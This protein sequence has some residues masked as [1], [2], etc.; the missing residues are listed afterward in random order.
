MGPF[1]VC[2]TTPGPPVS[3]TRRGHRPSSLA[4]GHRPVYNREKKG[5]AK[6]ANPH[7][8]TKAFWQLRDC[9]GAETGEGKRNQRKR[10]YVGE[11]AGA[12]GREMG[13]RGPEG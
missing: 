6:A 9:L 7:I 1:F 3:G 12:L 13:G 4:P 2:K 8:K 11:K 10:E 5:E